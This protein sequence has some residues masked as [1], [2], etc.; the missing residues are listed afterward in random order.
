M[1]RSKCRMVLSVAAGCL[2]AISCSKDTP[3]ESTPSS[4]ELY[5]PA[6]A[7]VNVSSS[8]SFTWSNINGADGYK[9]QISTNDQ[10]SGNCITAQITSTNYIVATPVSGFKTHFWR[11]CSYN[12]TGSSAWSA[13]SFFATG[14]TQQT[15]VP[16]APELASPSSGSIGVSVNARLIWSPSDSLST[17]GIQVSTDSTFSNISLQFIGVSGIY[18]DVTGYLTD[19]HKYFWRVR[20]TNLYGSSL[21]SLVYAFTTAPQVI[22]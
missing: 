15:S 4:P 20:A 5:S 21:W 7:V 19:N 13:K 9:I 3:T 8:P 22:P 11:V 6:Y 2:L 16:S 18:Q 10:F 1:L 12:N 14:G 17:Y